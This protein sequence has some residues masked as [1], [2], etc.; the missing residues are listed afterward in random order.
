MGN[1][2]ISSDCSDFAVAVGLI[3][4]AITFFF[5]PAAVWAQDTTPQTVDEFLDQWNEPSRD[6]STGPLW[7]WNDM[8]TEDQIRSTLQDLASQNVQQA[9]VHP[10]PGLMTPYL[11]DDWFRLWNVALDEAERLDMNIWIYDENSYP[12][13]FAGGF[14]PEAMPESRGQGLHFRETDDPGSIGADAVAAFQI[15]DDGTL[16][17]I[18]SPATEEGVLPVGRYLVGEIRLAPSSGWYGGT[19]YVDLLKPGVT[20]KFIEITMDAYKREL[21]D[22]FGERVPGWFTD[23]PQ[24][25]P[26]GGW[27]WTDDLPDRFEERW[28]Y[29]LIDNL[30][31]LTRK[32]GDWQRVRHNYRQLLLELFIERWA[33]P[34]YEYCEANDLE[35]TGHYWEHGWPDV[36]HGPDNMAMYAWHQR[37]SIDT[38]MNE[39]REDANAQFG[40][41]RAVKELAS[42]ANQM[43]CNRT[44]SEMYGAGGWDLTFDDMRRIGDWSYA[45]GVN[46]LNEHLSY[47]TI[48]GAR[49][50]DHPQSFSYH[51]PW[52]EAYHVMA[53][54]F[55]RLSV[56]LSSGKQVNRILLIEPTTTCWIYQHDPKLGQIGSD[57]QQM[58]NRLE[59]MQVEYD[60]GSEDVIMRH[61]SIGVFDGD[62]KFRVGECAYDLVV[63]PPHMENVNGSTLSLLTEY[64]AAGGRI[65]QCGPA[66]TFLDGVAS[67]APAEAFAAN[68]TWSE[69]NVDDACVAMLE[70]TF[71]DGLRIM[72]SDLYSDMY[73]HPGP[74]FHHR[75]R[76]ED[77]EIVFITNTSDKTMTINVQ[78]DKKASRRIYSEYEELGWVFSTSGF[79]YLSPH[80]SVLILY[81]DNPQHNELNGDIDGH[82]PQTETESDAQDPETSA[83]T[84]RLYAPQQLTSV[85][86]LDPNVLTI[87][88]VDATIGEE[89][90]ESTYFY[91]VNRWIWEQHGMDGNPWDSSV[92]FRDELISKTF[93]EGSGFSATYRFTLAEEIDG[94]LKF[95]VERPDLYTIQCNGQPIEAIEGEF[96]LDR[97]FGVLDVAELAQVG[98]NTVTITASPMTIYHELEPAYLIGDF[99]LTPVDSGF[100]VTKPQPLGPHFRHLI[101]DSPPG[102]A[103]YAGSDDHW[104]S[105]GIGL[106]EESP[107]IGDRNPSVTFTFGEPITVDLIRIWNYNKGNLTE[108]A[109]KEMRITHDLADSASQVVTLD[110]PTGR[111]ESTESP[112]FPQDIELDGILTN[113]IRF[114][115]LS[116]YHG[117]TYPVEEGVTPEDNGFVGLCEVKF[118]TRDEQG[119]LVEIQKVTAVAS[120]QFRSLNKDCAVWHL[121]DGSGVGYHDKTLIGWCDQGMPFYSGRVAY[122]YMIDLPSGY[123]FTRV[124]YAIYWHGSV[125][126][127]M[128][129]GIDA[130]YHYNALPIRDDGRFHEGENEITIIV[131]G[132]LKNTLGPHHAGEMRGK[133]WPRAFRE[134]PEIGPPPGESYDVIRYGI[135]DEE[136]N[137]YIR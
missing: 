75:R 111:E 130:G 59:R 26:A 58:I 134:G 8:L 80:E 71:N 127:V 62:A 61:G 33:R 27:S 131:Y 119:V 36:G 133:A 14:L 37:P 101:E 91:V 72:A 84:W 22:Q 113:A 16:R 93:P 126:K 68:E 73:L 50:R 40:N 38:L 34:C 82:A 136:L 35:F 60:L 79:Q 122:T 12:S 115:I 78:S 69:A 129:N 116:N 29:S 55:T 18:N 85:E 100:V 74:L 5:G 31:S 81:E 76:L 77:G 103:S 41:A 1:W 42:V 135:F 25:V 106:D 45:L 54:H 94:P 107:T 108:R 56:A 49:K 87:D 47:V 105:S 15:M 51:E 66:P 48:R 112:A 120:S 88:Y 46:T 30:G 109:V 63:L 43:G 21:G 117:T 137:V 10:R 90:R 128:V 44:L 20:E 96:Y 19:F 104:L 39:Y 67:D 98:E 95:V 4:L 3:L 102:H 6:Y 92:Q 89:T 53:D 99:S 24:L 17:R 132:T 57:F 23:E 125:A 118:Y 83:Y 9:W 7:T 64:A 124:P 123:H 32:T 86:R 121:V 70:R 13:G 2:T 11:S 97:A 52:W 110:R 28:G 65:L 114:D